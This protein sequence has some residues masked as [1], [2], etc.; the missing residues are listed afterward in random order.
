E[1]EA[2]G[3]AREILRLTRERA[4]ELKKVFN[5]DGSAQEGSRRLLD[6]ADQAEVHDK[7]LWTAIAKE[8]GAAGNSTALVGSYEQVAESL[9][10][11]VDL[12]VSTLLIRGFTP[13]ADATDYGNLVRL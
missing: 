3:R 7:R 8:T 10:D 2:W 11:Y 6:F 4:G 9:L 1:T 12:G 5:I 13:L